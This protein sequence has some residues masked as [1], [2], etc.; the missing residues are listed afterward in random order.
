MNPRKSM[1]AELRFDLEDNARRMKRLIDAKSSLSANE[2]MSLITNMSL[3]RH[4]PFDVREKIMGFTKDKDTNKDK[5]KEIL[6]TLVGERIFNRLMSSLESR[7]YDFMQ[8]FI[9]ILKL[10]ETPIRLDGCKCILDK[11]REIP[12][13]DRGGYQEFTQES[14]A[15]I[16]SETNP[17]MK[18]L[19][20]Y[21]CETL[22]ESLNEQTNYQISQKD[23]KHL[24]EAT[25]W[26]FNDVIFVV[27]AA[28]SKINQDKL[29]HDRF[30]KNLD[31]PD[32]FSEHQGGRKSR[33]RHYR[34]KRRGN[35][36]KYSRHGKYHRRK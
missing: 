14:Q 32:L 3:A 19:E 2:E 34:N 9:E 7:F 30:I 35:T 5:V 6:K 33:K 17:A 27:L 13:L 4:L 28:L 24:L 1:D 11:F 8:R 18:N 29:A 12:E 20:K 15:C 21:L 16:D 23:F 25:W 22:V 26:T 10:A 31:L 36:R